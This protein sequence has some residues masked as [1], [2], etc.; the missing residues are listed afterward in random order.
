MLNDRTSF[1]K[2]NYYI[3]YHSLCLNIQFFW[4]CFSCEIILCK[5]TEYIYFHSNIF[6]PQ[7]KSND[8]K[9]LFFRKELKLKKA[10]CE[11][12]HFFFFLKKQQNILKILPDHM[13]SSVLHIW[14]F[15]HVEGCLLQ[16]LRSMM[17]RFRGSA[18]FKAVY[19]GTNICR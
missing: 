8:K 18:S 16:Q 10:P 15:S 9:F 12:F 3:L 14:L 2:C 17:Q 7:K 5:S 4:Q 13:I 11:A 6:F 1:S 19:P